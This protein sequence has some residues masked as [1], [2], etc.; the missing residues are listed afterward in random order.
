MMGG[1]RENLRIEIY[2]LRFLPAMDKYILSERFVSL[3]LSLISLYKTL[4]TE[5]EFE[6][7]KKQIVRSS[8]SA[9]AN[10]RAACRAKS[11]ADFIYKLKVVL[12]EIDETLYLLE[13]TER[14]SSHELLKDLQKETNELIAII[15][16]AINTSSNRSS[17]S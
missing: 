11:T 17:K 15:V 13:I 16:A 2:D 7:I 6:V 1:A 12:E 4:P 8:M 3:S 10:Y 5:Y 14:I 9:G